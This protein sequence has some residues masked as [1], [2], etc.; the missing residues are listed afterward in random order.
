MDWT[1]LT[2]SDAVL[3]EIGR[4][5]IF[6]THIE[7]NMDILIGSLLKLD[8]EST[9]L[10]TYRV[11]FWKRLEML[12]SLLYSCSTAPD[13]Q[14]QRFNDFKERIKKVVPERNNCVHSMWS[15]EENLD[16]NLATRITY[17]RESKKILR[18]VE[19]VSLDQLK[20][21][22]KEL[23]QLNWLIGDIRV[24]VCRPGPH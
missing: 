12:E 5:T 24:Q 21:I 16:P 11:N 23:K 18:N 10:V 8:R 1:D 14:I 19:T 4:I 9:A 20:Q 3:C 6:Q 22:G 17:K 7:Q 2:V 13:E 15:F